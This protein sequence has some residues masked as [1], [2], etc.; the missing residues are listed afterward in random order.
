MCPAR[1][2][3]PH[4]G[5]RCSTGGLVFGVL[6]ACDGAALRDQLLHVEHREAVA[7]YDLLDRVKTVEKMPGRC[8]P[9]VAVIMQ[10]LR[11]SIVTTPPGR[12]GAL[13]PAKSFRS[14]TWRD[15]V[16]E[17]HPRGRVPLRPRGRL[18]SKNFTPWARPSLT[19]SAAV[20]AV[21]HAEPGRLCASTG[22]IRRCC[23]TFRLL[24]SAAQADLR[25]TTA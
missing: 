2:C 6:G 10:E 14:G 4:L 21:G 9:V 25:V 15:V 19:A 8:V 16:A 1:S 3:A 5:P 11:N 23:A 7:C 18:P 12:A 17:D 13:C 22:S 20:L 24:G